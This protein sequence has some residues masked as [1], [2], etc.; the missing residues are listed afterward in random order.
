MWPRQPA[1]RGPGRAPSSVAAAA[2]RSPGN[3]N[4]RQVRTQQREWLTFFRVKAL[5]LLYAYWYTGYTTTPPPARLPVPPHRPHHI[6]LLLFTVH[7]PGRYLSAD[8]PVTKDRFRVS[9]GS[10]WVDGRP[11][12]PGSLVS[13]VWVFFFQH[14]IAVQLLHDLLLVSRNAK[15]IGYCWKIVCKL[16]L[17]CHPRSVGTGVRSWTKTQYSDELRFM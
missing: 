14:E 15:L 16:R 7:S 3:P 10:G 1:G 17:H 11:M 12:L 6:S 2:C 9:G 8:T 4:A 13:F 5:L